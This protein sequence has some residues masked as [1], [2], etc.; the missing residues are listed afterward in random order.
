L[1]FKDLA[2]LKAVNHFWYRLGN[3]GRF[4]EKQILEH[5][6]LPILKIFDSVGQVANLPRFKLNDILTQEWIRDQDQSEIKEKLLLPAHHQKAGF[7]ADKYWSGSRSIKPEMNF[8]MPPASW[9]KIKG[10]NE[11]TGS[12]LVCFIEPTEFHPYSM[13]LF[14]DSA[15]RWG[16]IFR[17]TCVYQLSATTKSQKIEGIAT[18]HQAFPSKD[19]PWIWVDNVDIHLE[20]M[21]QNPHRAEII[22]TKKYCPKDH[23]KRWFLFFHQE[24]APDWPLHANWLQRFINGKECGWLKEGQEY[25]YAILKNNKL[26]KNGGKYDD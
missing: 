3:D 22:E 25:T 4:K 9:P 20:W 1:Q 12:S 14:I 2:N 23:L 10:V 6:P 13:G 26:T 7:N 11:N 5:I 24:S 15:K 16:F 8:N 21:I 19:S 18:L 17:Y